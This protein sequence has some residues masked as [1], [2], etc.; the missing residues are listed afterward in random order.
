M[1]ARRRARSG[2]SSGLEF[3]VCNV[4]V[5]THFFVL[6][7]LKFCQ[8]NISALVFGDGMFLLKAKEANRSKHKPMESTNK[9]ISRL[10]KGGFL[11]S[12]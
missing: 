3:P 9:N 4:G 11:G 10:Y 2:R 8:T 12:R 7:T 6:A 1:G 5:G